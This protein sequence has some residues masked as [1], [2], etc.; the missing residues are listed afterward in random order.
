MDDHATSLLASFAASAIG[1]V[2]AGVG[3]ALG[4]RLFA[5]VAKPR[6]RQRSV[7]PAEIPHD[8]A[9]RVLVLAPGMHTGITYKNA[10]DIVAAM[11]ALGP[12]PISLVIHTLG[13]DASAVGYLA[14]AIKNSKSEVLAYVPYVAMSGG[15][16][17]ALAANRIYMA[18]EAVLG[19]V[20]PQLAWGPAQILK[21]LESW[22]KEQVGPAWYVAAR[23]AKLEIAESNALLDEL[24]VAESA[25]GRLASGE[26]AHGQV[27]TF[28]EA[29]DIGI[30][31]QAGIPDHIREHLDFLIANEPD[32]L[33]LFL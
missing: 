5:D 11:N 2:A 28:R 4:G 23:E 3:I 25:K 32:L 9:R 30:K 29:Q 21:D 26:T 19:P 22:P 33:A 10:I 24:G 16:V 31:V 15:T 17:V 7:L 6:P 27:I 12:G 1:G 14:R 20:D 13:G 8:L 18:R